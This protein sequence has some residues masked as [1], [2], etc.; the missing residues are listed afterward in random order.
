MLFDLSLCSFV[1]V[2]SGHT[3]QC[4]GLSPDSIS[5]DHSLLEAQETI[6]NAG[7]KPRLAMCKA[8]PT[9]TIAWSSSLTNVGKINVFS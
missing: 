3:Q 7:T 4:L 9:H 1:L 5:Q 6:W 2:F 8:C